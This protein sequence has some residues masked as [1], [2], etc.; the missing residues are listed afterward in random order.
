MDLD[1]KCQSLPLV[2]IICPAIF[3]A[4]RSSSV[5]L[6]AVCYNTRAW[7]ATS[8]QEEKTAEC[9]DFVMKWPG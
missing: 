3:Q 2:S 4:Q 7:R 1:P 9:D 5:E 6:Q 8:I